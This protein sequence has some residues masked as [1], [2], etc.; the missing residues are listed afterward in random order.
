MQSKKRRKKDQNLCQARP[1]GKNWADTPLEILVK[2]LP[3]LNDKTRWRNEATKKKN[4]P[5]DF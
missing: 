3:I 2:Q 1:A 4:E 5:L